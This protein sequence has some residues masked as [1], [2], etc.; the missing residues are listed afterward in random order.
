MTAFLFLFMKKGV[1]FLPITLNYKF[2]LMFPTWR[3]KKKKT[4]PRLPPFGSYD[5]VTTLLLI[6]ADLK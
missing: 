5:A 4:D 1:Y 2:F 6:F 3:I